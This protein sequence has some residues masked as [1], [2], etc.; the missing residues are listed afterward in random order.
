MKHLN[1]FNILGLALMAF[2]TFSSAYTQAG[3]VGWNMSVGGGYGGAWHPAA[4][5]PYGPSWGPGWRG[6]W[7]Y[8]GAY[9]SP[10]AG[11]Y[12]P[13][14][15]IYAAPPQPLV[16]AAQPEP[17]VWYYCEASGIYYPYVQE[18]PAGWQKQTVT[19]PT[20]SAQPKQLKH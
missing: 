4:Y 2:L 18:C 19:P 7:G 20:S 15:V 11:Y 9:Y 1:K 10:Y 8:P 14:T 5:G 13:P 16:L 17:A 12:G 3:H 6:N